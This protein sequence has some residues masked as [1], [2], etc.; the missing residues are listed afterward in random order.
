MHTYDSIQ[1]R[2]EVVR[3]WHGDDATEAVKEGFDWPAGTG[4]RNPKAEATIGLDNRRFHLQD[5]HKGLARNTTYIGVRL[6]LREECWGVNDE[7]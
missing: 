5:L 2:L 1:M 4:Q 6:S 7:L 3:Q